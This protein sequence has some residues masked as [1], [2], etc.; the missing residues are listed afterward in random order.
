MVM[1][2][3]GDTRLPT[4]DRC[5]V[6]T[7]ILA[8]CHRCGRYVCSSCLDRRSEACLE[9]LTYDENAGVRGSA[10]QFRGSLGERVRVDEKAL[11]GAA[12]RLKTGRKPI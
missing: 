4:C 5:G 1:M 9:C 11:Q 8:K 7:A 3:D 6:R 10:C 12:G 2:C